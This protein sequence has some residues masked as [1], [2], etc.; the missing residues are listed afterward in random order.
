M[1]LSFI[2]YVSEYVYIYTNSLTLY[3][4]YYI[5]S[6]T[7]DF[8]WH[9]KT[10]L[11]YKNIWSV[12]LNIGNIVINSPYVLNKYLYCAG[13]HLLRLNL[14]PKNVNLFILLYIIRSVQG[15]FLASHCIW[16]IDNNNVNARVNGT[17]RLHVQYVHV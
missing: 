17:Y 14:H 5:I 12:S 7:Y 10:T 9:K 6:I 15:H 11:R 16:R 8:F 4:L 3:Y 2:F 1:L 13:K